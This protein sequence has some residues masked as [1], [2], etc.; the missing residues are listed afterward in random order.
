VIQ[1]SKNSGRFQTVLSL[2]ILSILVI[3][4]AGIWMTQFQFNPAV[5]KK[6]AFMP[7][8]TQTQA[9]S[10]LTS[11]PHFLPLPQ[12]IKPLTEAEMFDAGNLSDKINGKA[13]LYLSAGFTRLVSQRFK[14]VGPGDL[15]MEAFVYDMGNSQN[16]F[17]VFSTQRREGSESLDLAENA[18]RTPNAVFLAHGRYYVEIISSKVSEEGRQPLKLMAETFVQKTPSEKPILNESALFPEEGLVQDSVALIASN[19]FGFEGFNKIYTAEYELGDQGLMAYL[20]RR[21]SAAEATE[22]ASAYAK[23]LLSYGG[24]EIEAQLPIKGARLIEVLDTYEI[25]FSKGLSLAGVR[26]SATA[27]QAKM[28]ASRLYDRLKE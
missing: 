12:G 16:A 25:V 28:L 2:C 6:E 9:A 14:D 7:K 4:G 1:K 18:Y 3:I 17:S 20:S 8:S 22:M 21:G 13:E 15:W 26:D 10:P 23:F 5:L 19:A 24:K 27:E 11:N